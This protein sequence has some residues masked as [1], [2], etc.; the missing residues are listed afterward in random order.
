[1]QTYNSQAAGTGASYIY[2][3]QLIYSKAQALSPTTTC[4]LN[5]VAGVSQPCS[6]RDYL[7]QKYTNNGTL[8]NAAGILALDTAWHSNYDSGDS[9]VARESQYCKQSER[10][11]ARLQYLTLRLMHKAVDPYR[12]LISVGGKADIGDCTWFH[13]GPGSLKCESS[14]VEYTA[15]LQ[16]PHIGTQEGFSSISCVSVYCTITWKT[17]SSLFHAGT[18]IKLTRTGGPACNQTVT[19][20]GSP[21]TLSSTFFST[22]CTGAPGR[23]DALA[24]ASVMGGRIQIR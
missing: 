11:M 4:S 20:V 21:G 3:Q 7:W 12:V 17:R 24:A 18:V 8:S 10:V 6:L 9:D 13:R 16:S 2:L 15:A 19:L 1:M 14:A 22:S 23:P 5:Y